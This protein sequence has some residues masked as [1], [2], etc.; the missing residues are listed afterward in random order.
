M[1]RVASV[2][3]A[4]HLAMRFVLLICYNK[5]MKISTKVSV[6]VAA[7]IVIA[8]G[9]VIGVNLANRS[10]N[11]EEEAVV[12]PPNAEEMDTSE[13]VYISFYEDYEPGG[14]VVVELDKN[15]LMVMDYLFSSAVNADGELEDGS[16]KDYQAVIPADT[17]EK[18]W[19]ILRKYN[20][21]FHLDDNPDYGFY[22]NDEDE[23][24]RNKFIG[25]K[26]IQPL[27]NLTRTLASFSKGEI[28]SAELDAEVEQIL[29]EE[30][31][32]L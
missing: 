11:D 15:N 22:F 20:V 23:A 17:L 14:R 7:L 19:M 12:V 10:Q 3:L 8:T 31:I 24:V 9:I 5:S 25:D 6:A 13:K 4:I 30:M 1:G 16:V 2:I 28:T 32:N 29:T 21:Y 26:Q 27:Q 18:I